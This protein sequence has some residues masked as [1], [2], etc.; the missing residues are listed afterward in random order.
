[1]ASSA[2]SPAFLHTVSEITKIYRSLP[3]RPS[4]EQVEAAM[5]TVETVDKEEQMKLDEISMQEE[6]EGVS[7]EL[8]SVLQELKKIVFLFQS[9]EQKREALYLLELEKMFKTAGD[10]IQRAS[11]LVSGD[12]QNEKRI[13]CSEPVGK[14]EKDVINDRSLAERKEEDEQERDN[15]KVEKRSSANSSFSA[16]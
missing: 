14:F 4:I 3:L 15:F 9:H 2:P 16:G 7:D 13:N 11:E 12:I 1:M 5:S 10:L 6:P 8:F